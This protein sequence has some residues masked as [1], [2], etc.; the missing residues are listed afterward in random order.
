MSEES[1]KY[2]IGFLSKSLEGKSL[3]INILKKLDAKIDENT[4]KEPQRIKLS[5]LINKEGTAYFDFIYFSSDSSEIVKN[6]NKELETNDEIMRFSVFSSSPKKRE[7]GEFIKEL[8]E[9]PLE[10]SEIK[11][12]YSRPTINKPRAITKPPE[13]L[14]NEALEKKLEEMLK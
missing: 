7:E 5:Y 4:L 3:I 8:S 10:I 11:E 9:K 14:T 6:I 2:E 1:K 12:S 13:E